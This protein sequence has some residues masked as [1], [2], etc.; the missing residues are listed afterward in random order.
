M[1]EFLYVDIDS[2][3]SQHLIRPMDD[4]KLD[5]LSNSIRKHGIIE[6]LIVTKE[7]ESYRLIAGQRRLAAAKRIG[8]AVVPCH[9]LKSDLEEAMAISLHENL[10]RQ[11]LSTIDEFMLFKYMKISLSYTSSTIAQIAGKSTSY[12]SQRLDMDSWE[13]ELF[14]ALKANHI[15]FSVAR[16]LSQVTDKRHLLYLLKY[17]I[18]AGANYRTVHSWV[19]QWKAT[20][21]QDRVVDPLSSDQESPPTYVPTK[22]TCELCK[23]QFEPVHIYTILSCISCRN[24]LLIAIREATT[25]Q[26]PPNQT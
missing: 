20:P 22:V 13:P 8:L 14:E 7:N 12:I 15:N 3:T 23:G 21:V 10:F 4:T 26:P 16:E 1:T 2:I 5:E 11:D 17:A 25:K 6:P 9:I 24:E 18:D 19:S